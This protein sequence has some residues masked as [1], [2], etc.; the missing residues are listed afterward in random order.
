MIYTATMADYYVV[1]DGHEFEGPFE[2]R[3]SAKK[4]ADQLN[5]NEVGGRYRVSSK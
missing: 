3:K 4:R 1:V 5:T 2:D